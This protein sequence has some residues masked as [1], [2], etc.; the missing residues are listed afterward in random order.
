MSL[1]FH[2]G[3]FV[4]SFP[5]AQVYSD[6]LEYKVEDAEYRVYNPIWDGKTGKMTIQV[7]HKRGDATDDH[8]ILHLNFD[9]QKGFLAN[10]SSEIQLGN[11]GY[12]IPEYV[13]VPIDFTVDVLG[14]L[15]AIETMG[16]SDV[17]ADSVMAAFDGFCTLYNTTSQLGVAGNDGGGRLY[18]AAAVSHVLNRACSCVSVNP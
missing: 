18:M 4:Q 17:V 5:H 13:T 3:A 8:T 9:L 16:I 6:H 7:D 1:Q 12:T 2:D 10:Y 11:D 15:G 14:Q